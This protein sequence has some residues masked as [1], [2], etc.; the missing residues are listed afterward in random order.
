MAS[1]VVAD[2][3]PV[4]AAIGTCPGHDMGNTY[5]TIATL[6]EIKLGGRARRAARGLDGGWFEAP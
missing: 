3:V 1:N 5:R 2:V 4:R 6:G